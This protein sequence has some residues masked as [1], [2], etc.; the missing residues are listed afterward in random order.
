MPRSVWLYVVAL[1]ILGVILAVGSSVAAMHRFSISRETEQFWNL[2]IQTVLAFW[3]RA[4]RRARHFNVP[5][6]FDAFVFFFW[7]V[8]VPYYFCK[9]RGFRG[10]LLS[11]GVY[12]LIFVPLAIAA[13]AD[14][15]SRF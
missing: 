1:S 6:E 9:T 8:V 13:V 5:F 10:L 2:S 14:L 12:A 15:A 3:V 4:D 7:P 11:L